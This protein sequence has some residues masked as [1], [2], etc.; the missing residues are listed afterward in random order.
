ML[1]FLSDPHRLCRIAAGR[2]RV[3]QC[4]VIAPPSHL[5]VD[6]VVGC[7]HDSFRDLQHADRHRCG[8]HHQVSL[9]H[10]RP[11]TEGKKGRC[12]GRGDCRGGLCW[13]NNE[14]RG[15]RCTFLHCYGFPKKISDDDPWLLNSLG[16]VS[17]AEKRS[18]CWIKACWGAPIK[19]GGA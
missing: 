9:L 5:D 16:R 7:E 14:C 19:T 15:F 13:N 4:D 11:C 2:I 8:T 10:R 3:G 18:H 6:C 1:S 12:N 17:K